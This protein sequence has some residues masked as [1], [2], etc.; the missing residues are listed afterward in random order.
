MTRALLLFSPMYTARSA[1]PNPMRL[2]VSGSGAASSYEASLPGREQ[3]VQ[4]DTP[5]TADQKY[6]LSF[7]VV[8]N[9]P[10]SDPVQVWF[11]PSL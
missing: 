10:P 3:L 11:A 4:L 6:N 2:I 1:L 7:Q 5:G 9:L 8:D